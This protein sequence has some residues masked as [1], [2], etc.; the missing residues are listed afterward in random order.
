[1]QKIFLLLCTFMCMAGAYA[2]NSFKIIVK[3]KQSNTAM[4]DATILVKGTNI[5]LKTLPDGTAS[6]NNIPNGNQTILIRNIGFEEY[7]LNL[8]FPL[9]QEKP[10][11]ILMESA[12][13]ELEEVIV[14]ST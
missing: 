1:M 14:S 7:K 12:E 8:N 11:E 9:N 10:L 5:I 4:S 2:Q 3:T 13:D 6:I